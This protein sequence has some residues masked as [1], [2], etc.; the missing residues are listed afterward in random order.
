MN[1]VSANIAGGNTSKKNKKTGKKKD[2]DNLLSAIYSSG[3]K[4]YCRLV[5]EKQ[6]FAN[7]DCNKAFTG[8][9]DTKRDLRGEVMGTML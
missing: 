6:D 9:K 7:G 3:Y 2:Q 1:V 5:L 4:T 8:L